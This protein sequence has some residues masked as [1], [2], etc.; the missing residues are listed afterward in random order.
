M[1]DL[2]SIKPILCNVVWHK[3]IKDETCV[4]LGAFRYRAKIVLNHF[5]ILMRPYCNQGWHHHHMLPSCNPV[6]GLT[7]F[8]SAPACTARG[9]SA[10]AQGNVTF[11]DQPPLNRQKKRGSLLTRA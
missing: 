7:S 1:V 2:H 11:C 5:E 6:V 10:V 8:T 3:Q 4:F 9:L